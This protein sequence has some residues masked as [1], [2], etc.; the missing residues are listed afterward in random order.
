MMVDVKEPSPR[1][2]KRLHEERS[3]GV[4]NYVNSTSKAVRVAVPEYTTF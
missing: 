1:L 4:P 2:A 3:N